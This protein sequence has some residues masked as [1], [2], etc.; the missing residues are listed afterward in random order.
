MSTVTTHLSRPHHENKSATFLLSH[1]STF[2]PFMGWV[3]LRSGLTLMFF[4]GIPRTDSSTP[5]VRLSCHLSS[6]TYVLSCL[7]LIIPCF[8]GDF[9]TPAFQCPHQVECVGMLGDGSLV[10]THLVLQLTSSGG[11]SCMCL[12]TVESKCYKSGEFWARVG[13][14]NMRVGQTGSD[15]GI[16][17]KRQLFYGI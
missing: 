14:Q 1:G 6:I 15:T 10:V 16:E 13:P 9:F 2:N 17:G 3:G 5:Y 11:T 4:K 7:Y 8:P 12:A